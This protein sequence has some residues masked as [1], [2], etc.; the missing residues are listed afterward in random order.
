LAHDLGAEL[1][2][3]RQWLYRHHRAE[4]HRVARKEGGAQLWVSPAGV[5]AARARQGEQTGQVASLPVETPERLVDALA[6]TVDPSTHQA[7]GLDASLPDKSASTWTTEAVRQLVAA[8]RLSADLS[9]RLDE[10]DRE[11]TE[12]REAVKSANGQVDALY[13]RV[14]ELERATGQLGERVRA[15][16]DWYARVAAASWW[17]RRRLP[18]APEDV[19]PQLVE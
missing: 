16:R 14:G 18:D 7:G 13:R 15:W 9:A 2:A 3:L 5:A 11:L 8:E 19:K 12:V 6:F 10:R 4:L 1:G 17:R